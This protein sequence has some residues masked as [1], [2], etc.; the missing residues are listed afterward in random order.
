VSWAG[1]PERQVVISGIGQSVIGRKLER[2]GLQLTL[3]AITAAVTDAGIGLSDVDGLA[4]YPGP[5]VNYI[6]GL[7]GPDLYD[8]ADALRLSL[9]WH[10]S[11]PQGCGQIAPLVSAVMAVAARLCRAR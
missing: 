6:P 7:V 4:T 8:T 1:R 3:D 11:T 10:L 2:S 9:G 5:I